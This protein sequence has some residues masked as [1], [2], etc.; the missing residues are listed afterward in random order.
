[1]RTAALL[2]A[3]T[4]VRALRPAMPSLYQRR[5]PVVNLLDA[6]GQSIAP[7]TPAGSGASDKDHDVLLG[8][9]IFSSRDPRE[10]VASAPELYTEDFLKFVSDKAEDSDDMEEREGLKSLVDMIRATLAAVEKMQ[11]E[12][13]EAQARIEAE[14]EAEAERA[15]AL[16]RGEVVVDTEQVLG[17][18]AVA[19]GIEQYAEMAREA[20]SEGP[21][22]AGLYGDAL[23]TYDALLSEFV[24]AEAK[25]EL[26]AAVEGAFERCDYSLLALATERRDA[27][28]RPDTQALNA[29]IEAVNALSAKRLEQAAARLGTVMQQGSPEKMFAKIQELAIIN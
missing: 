15:A 14:V 26:A 21:G 16:A 17:A 24:Q 29:I 5:A 18:A 2:V 19:S 13:E 10:D 20:R 12:A 6:K 1:M 28:D 7:V 25:G 11:K 3:A 22:E 27:G 4:T 8:E 9:L 23:R